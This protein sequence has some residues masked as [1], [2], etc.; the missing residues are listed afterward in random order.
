M[1]SEKG[2]LIVHQPPEP[3]AFPGEGRDDRA[4]PVG[5]RLGR[6][7]DVLRAAVPGFGCL[8][9]EAALR[10]QVEPP[11]LGLPHRRPAPV[12]LP[13]V[14]AGLEGQ[15]PRQRLGRPLPLEVVVPEG[16]E[17]VATEAQA[18]VLPPL[19]AAEPGALPPGLG[20]GPGPDDQ[21]RA[22]PP[23]VVA[24]HRLVAEHGAVEVLGVEEAVHA[25]HGH[26]PR[27]PGQVLLQGLVAPVVV[28][29]GVRPAGASRPAAGRPRSAAPARR[30]S[31]PRARPGNG[32]G[33]PRGWSGW[34]SSSR[35][36]GRRTAA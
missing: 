7:R 36:A 20:V 30:W 8:E 22:R 27:R 10:L 33:S 4:H 18:G 23:G 5:H 24:G 13:A 21:V 29:G 15:H 19:E 32:R 34:R 12:A 31:R 26:P 6:V 35:S 14:A 9:G 3:G 1:R 11:G 25:E 17:H 16:L 2:P 28:V